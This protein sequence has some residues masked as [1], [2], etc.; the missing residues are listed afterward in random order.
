M[1]W[2]GDATDP[3]WMKLVAAAEEKATPRWIHH[4]VSE[5]D[6]RL[7]AERQKWAKPT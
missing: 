2:H 3:E 1:N 4:K 5:L 6:I 7:K